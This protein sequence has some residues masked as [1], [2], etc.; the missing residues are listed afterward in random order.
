MAG[1]DDAPLDILRV[2]HDKIKINLIL[3]ADLERGNKMRNSSGYKLGILIA[4]TIAIFGLGV[5]PVIAQSTSDVFLLREYA[6]ERSEN[7]YGELIHFYF[8][9]HL[10]LLNPADF[11]SVSLIDPDGIVHNPELFTLDDGSLSSLFQ[12]LELDEKP[13]GEFILTITNSDGTYE[14]M[15]LPVAE[16]DVSSATPVIITPVGLS[17][18][19]DGTPLLSWEPFES[20]EKGPEESMFYMLEIFSPLCIREDEDACWRVSVPEEV[21]SVIYNF[22]KNAYPG[23]EELPPGG[24]TFIVFANEQ[25][26]DGLYPDNSVQTRTSTRYSPFFVVHPVYVNLDIRPDSDSNPINCKN[27]LGIIAV[28]ILTTEN[29]D[30]TT[31]NHTTVTFEGA[32]EVHVDRKT[33][34]PK[35]HIE[36][37]DLDG[38]LDIVFHFRLGDTNLTCESEEG[39]ITGETFDGLMIEGTDSISQTVTPSPYY[40]ALLKTPDT[41]Q[42]ISIAGL[43]GFG[44]LVGSAMVFGAPVQLK[45]RKNR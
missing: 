36:D 3:L 22:D 2:P 15:T 4:V 12:K 23:F 42:I 19:T 45:R 24:Y 35:R 33:G 5:I 34:E 27:E 28:A 7:I 9:A 16:S 44:L 10:T 40:S 25:I 26:S 21:T 8:A 43:L 30:A 13:V 31:V 6:V 38:D 41:P 17:T 29:F 1:I 32:S 20:P 18:I 11:E 14:T 37:V 39:T